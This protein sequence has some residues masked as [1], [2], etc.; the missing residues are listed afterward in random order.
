MWSDKWLPFPSLYKL[1]IVPHFFPDDAMVSTLINLE[2][3]TWK[4]NIIHEVF[5]P[6]DAEAI[7]SI[8]L[9]PSLLADRL[10]W[11]SIPMGHFSMSSAYQVTC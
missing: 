1:A 9:S 4:S 8:P 2:T 6:F 10:I 3:T 11:A 5:L 7:L